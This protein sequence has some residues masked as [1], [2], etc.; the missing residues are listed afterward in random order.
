MFYIS[1]S[2]SPGILGSHTSLQDVNP[3]NWRN[4]VNWDK[5]ERH[6]YTTLND[7]RWTACHKMQKNGYICDNYNNAVDSVWRLTLRERCN[8]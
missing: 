1:F 5:G 8:Q 6:A 4:A 2:F 7:R 3:C